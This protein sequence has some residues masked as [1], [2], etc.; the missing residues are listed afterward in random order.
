MGVTS[1]SDAHQHSFGVDDT[2]ISLNSRKNGYLM[3]LLLPSWHVSD[4]TKDT[5]RSGVSIL[6]RTQLISSLGANG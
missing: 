1:P 4:Q 2:A 3:P 6:V 5:I